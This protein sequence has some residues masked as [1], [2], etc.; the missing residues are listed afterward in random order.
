MHDVH[1]KS[2][3]ITLLDAYGREL[4]G[5]SGLANQADGIRRHLSHFFKAAAGLGAITRLNYTDGVRVTFENG[6]VAPLRPSGNADEL[7]I[8]AVSDSQSRAEEIT[9]LATAEPDGILRSM[10]SFVLQTR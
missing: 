8:Y 3:R 9:T 4:S 10:E 1:F 5:R 6:D 2:D 7:R